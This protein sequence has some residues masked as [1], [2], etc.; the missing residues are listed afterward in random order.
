M[1][2]KI[3]QTNK[4]TKRRKKKEKENKTK[5]E[6]TKQKQKRAR[7]TD[8]RLTALF[9]TLQQPSSFKMT[10]VEMASRSLSTRPVAMIYFGRVWGP[11][12]NR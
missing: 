10:A 2:K 8:L 7:S 4:Q 9:F 1:I 3:N 5:T 6:K 11:H 12:K